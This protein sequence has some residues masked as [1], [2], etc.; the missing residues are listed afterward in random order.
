[1][2]FSSERQ[3]RAIK[4]FFTFYLT[5]SLGGILRFLVPAQTFQPLIVSSN[6]YL[7]TVCVRVVSDTLFKALPQKLYCS[8]Q[9]SLRSKRDHTIKSYF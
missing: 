1:M 2:A 6:I 9:S 8:H 3:T 5:A 4:F 7:D